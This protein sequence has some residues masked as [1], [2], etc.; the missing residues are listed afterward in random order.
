[1]SVLPVN[2][3]KA[4]KASRQG[5]LA[6]P[7]TCAAAQGRWYWPLTAYAFQQ[8]PTPLCNVVHSVLVLTACRKLCCMDVHALALYKTH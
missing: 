6:Y 3:I 1:V 7:N 4:F 2:S 5:C 8:K